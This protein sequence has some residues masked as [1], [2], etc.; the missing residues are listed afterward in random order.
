MF[1]ITKIYLKKQP[2][3]KFGNINLFYYIIY[4]TNLIIIHLVSE[5][6]SDNRAKHDHNTMKT[7]KNLHPTLNYNKMYYI[8]AINHGH[9]LF[10]FCSLRMF[11]S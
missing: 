9:N 3:C 2:T 8:F 7:K 4:H 11:E 1:S 5:L 10:F 6:G